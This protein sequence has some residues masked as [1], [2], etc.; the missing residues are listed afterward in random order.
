MRALLSSPRRRRRA[1]WLGVLA[2]AV[3][4]VGLSLVYLRNTV[5]PSN[6]KVTKAAPAV[7]PKQVPRRYSGRER[8]SAIAVA[9]EFLQTAVLRE[10]I[11]RSWSIT[12]PSLR[13]G[14]TRRSWDSGDSLPFPPYHF[15]QVRWRPDYSYRN[16]IGLQ[17]ALF[18]AKT[19]TQRPEVFFI[20]LRRHGRGGHD[21]WLVSSFA[22]APTE[23]ST[24]TPAAA[25]SA[26][27]VTLPAAGA[28]KAPLSAAW[29]LL[30]ISGLSL[31]VLIPA[32][33]GIRG[34]VRNRRAVRAYETKVLPPLS[35]S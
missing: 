11:D 24:P 33:L 23:G 21:H 30:P 2:A 34:Y 26:L 20:D 35:K 14:Y 18:P 8:A 10:H 28:E 9:A 29:L 3:L 7:E 32:A 15:A 27:H 31:I 16:A 12:E 13:R 22:P 1:A 17:V 6:E 4:A 5:S 19:E 25:G